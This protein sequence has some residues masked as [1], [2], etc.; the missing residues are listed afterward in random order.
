MPSASPLMHGY[1]DMDTT[2]EP[3]MA[4][5][6]LNI[7]AHIGVNAYRSSAHPMLHALAYTSSLI[8]HRHCESTHTCTHT[9]TN[10]HT[11]TLT[12]MHVI[13]YACIDTMCGCIADSIVITRII[14]T[15]S[16]TVANAGKH[17]IK[18]AHTRTLTC[19]HVIRYAC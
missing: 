13:R 17:L 18:L 12:R 16:C 8:T 11:H 5:M 6:V 2:P 10:T 4:G 19:M 9:H 7:C 1:A 15:R 14:I 3:S